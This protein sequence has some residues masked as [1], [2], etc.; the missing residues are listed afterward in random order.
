MKTTIPESN[1]LTAIL[2]GIAITITAGI[3]LFPIVYLAFAAFFE[4]YVFTD[5]PPNAWI[6]DYFLIAVFGLWFFV[7]TAAGGWACAGASE[8]DEYSRALFLAILWA[9]I[10]LLFYLYFAKE[11]PFVTLLSVIAL[12]I[13]G[14]FTGTMLRMRKKRAHQAIK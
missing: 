11:E 9:V 2:T 4:L 8:R 12:G 7:A 14:Y 5:P 3:I 13:T 1:F 6:R 10:A